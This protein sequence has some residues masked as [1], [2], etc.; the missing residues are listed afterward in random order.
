MPRLFFA[1]PDFYPPWR[2]DVEE[3]FVRQMQARGIKVTWSMRRDRAGPCLQTEHGGQVVYLPLRLSVAGVAG[4]VINK[5]TQYLCEVALFFCLLFGKR[6]DIIQVRDRRY[7]FAFLGWL[8]A[9]LRGAKFVFWSSYPFP[10]HL[11]EMATGKHWAQRIA[12]LFRGHLSWFYVYR[13]IMVVADHVFVQSEQ[14]LRDV[15]RYGVP[16][17]KMTPVP[18]GVPPHLLDWV[19]THAGEGVQAGKVVYV[20]TFARVRRMDQIIEAF[21]L[22]RQRNAHAHLFMVGAGDSPA[23]RAEL[24]AQT[25]RL[26]LAE[27]VTFT[28][29]VPMEE[30]WRHAASAEVCLSPFYPTF[31][32]RST[33]P[34]KLVEY[35]ALGRHGGGERSSGAGCHSRRKWRGPVCAVGD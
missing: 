8:V 35:M 28:G 11:V 3:L 5:I 25:Q 30:A 10:E 27:A 17:S 1:V 12:L 34:T 22:V 32:L 15:A 24:E 31:V 14:M 18:M 29:F 4:K 7:L 33:S 13:F 26:G 20:G 23:E 19:A 6:F 2:L 16:V 21:R 9:R